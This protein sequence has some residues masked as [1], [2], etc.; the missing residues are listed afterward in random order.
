MS[1]SSRSSPVII[2]T[3]TPGTG[4]S[5]HAQL[6]AEESPVPLRHVNVGELVKDKD[7]HEGYDEE[8]QSYTVDED[9]LLD[10]LEP[11]A[12]EGGII[13]D[14][15][16]CD[17]FPERWADLVV[18]LRCDHTKLW[19]RLEK[20]GYPLKKIQE[21]NEAEIMDIVIEEARSSYAQEIIVELRSEGTEDLESNVSRIVQWIQ[22][23]RK[24]RGATET[25]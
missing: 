16:T 7:L 24:D 8:W 11:L 5:T 1:P 10:E 17:I 4:K 12:S 2:I 6:L 14:W 13:L 23:W 9:K 20:R 25:D 18:V 19:E 21:N 3:G 15:H 22:A